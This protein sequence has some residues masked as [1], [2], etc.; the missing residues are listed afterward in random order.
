MGLNGTRTGS[1]GG[2]CEKFRD[3]QAF[4][5]PHCLQDVPFIPAGCIPDAGINAIG[6]IQAAFD[7]REER[8]QWVGRSGADD[9]SDDSVELADSDTDG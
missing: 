6:P 8:M 5:R 7:K 4:R 9:D 2:G 1:R 3:I